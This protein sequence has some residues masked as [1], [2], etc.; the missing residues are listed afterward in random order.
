LII[1]YIFNCSIIPLYVCINCNDG[2][3]VNN[4][5]ANLQCW[6]KSFT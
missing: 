3:G 5:P 2:D 1:N 6:K 4:A